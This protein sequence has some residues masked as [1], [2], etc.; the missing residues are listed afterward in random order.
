MEVG[1]QGTAAADV[2]G[3]AVEA[4]T[5]GVGVAYIHLYGLDACNK[6]TCMPQIQSILI[7]MNG[8]IR[9]SVEI[10]LKCCKTRWNNLNVGTHRGARTFY[11]L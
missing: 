5:Q 8:K 10:D 3:P 1:L 7:Q 9:T 4:P 11:E 2:G 6:N